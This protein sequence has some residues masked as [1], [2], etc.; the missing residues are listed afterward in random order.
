MKTTITTLALAVASAMSF[1][2]MAANTPSLDVY[3]KANIT[4]Q[5]S[6][7]GTGSFTELKSN[8]SRIG[9]KGFLNLDNNLQVVY[10]A[11]Y[12]VDIVSAH[13]GKSNNFTNR[14]Q[15]IGLKG[16]FGKV[17]LGTN[18]TILKQSQGKVDLFNDLSGDIK[19]LWKGE[20][21]V[22]NTVTY[23]TPSMNNLHVGVTYIANGAVGGKTGTSI[24]AMYGD[25]K[26]KKTPF[27]AALSVDNNVKGYDVTR[28]TFSTKA[29]AVTLG[30]M[31]QHQKSDA[32]VEMN[33]YLVSA[34][35]SI[36][37]VALKAQYQ[38]AD[39][40][41]ADKNKGFSVGADYKLAKT[42][43]VFA[44]YTTLNFQSAMNQKY[45]AVGIEQKF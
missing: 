43:K 2:S 14:N 31:Y 33:G 16:N 35:Y 29:N 22:G 1:S 24:A 38:V 11:E 5:S 28:A 26:L 40:K 4:L 10:Q 17:L 20:N 12:E 37:D 34:K 21:R 45:L 30:A 13:G 23:I 18:D 19:H 3:G 15:F 42:T 41:N 25:S 27:Y 36:N 9:F 6:D 7:T 44:F 8:A 32:G 39:F